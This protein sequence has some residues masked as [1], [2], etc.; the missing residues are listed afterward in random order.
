MTTSP[1]NNS[2]NSTAVENA[3]RLTQ[4]LRDIGPVAVAYSGGVD[5][6]VVAMAAFI[7]WNDQTVAVTAVSPSLAVS[8]RTIARDEAARIGI[9]HIELETS[10]FDRAEYRRNSGDRCYFCKDTLYTLASSQL[11]KLGVKC[12]VNGA[13]ADD[14]GDHRPG[15]KAATDHQVRSPLLELGMT[16]VDVR[17][18]AGFWNLSVADKPAAPC[19][20]SRVAYGVEVTE[21]RVARI[22]KAEA[23]IREFT[24]IRVLRVRCEAN[25]L[26]RIEVPVDQ[27]SVIIQSDVRERI[28]SEL[29]SFGFRA[30][31]IDLDGFRSGNLNDALPLV[32]LSMRS[33]ES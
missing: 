20:A 29:K 9:R 26:A 6:A 16:K 7:A 25:E 18:L 4:L 5:S 1:R 13:N 21:E 15:M 32:Q 24:G 8:E 14:V 10:E 12:L 31:T 22:E 17:Q 11:Q 2:M 33:S 23:L 28:T 30:V 3:E 27:L 19:L